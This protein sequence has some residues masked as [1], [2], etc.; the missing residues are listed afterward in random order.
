MPKMKIDSPKPS[1][2]TQGP[3]LL[4]PLTKK[5]LEA[6]GVGEN[7]AVDFLDPEYKTGDPFLLKGMDQAVARIFEAL[8]KKEKIVVFADYDADGIPGAVVLSDFFTAIGYS[9]FDVYIPH[10]YEEGF[11]LNLPAI[12]SFAANGVSLIITIDCGSADREP[13]AKA[14][15]LNM[16]VIITDH[17]RPSDPEP[18]ALVLV[19]PNK[20]GDTYPF[21]GLSGAG[22]VFKLVEALLVR[23]QDSGFMNQATSP[24]PPGWEK[25]L[26]DMVG[27]STLSDMVPLLGENRMFAK[28]G[29]KVFRKSRRPGLRALLKE[30]RIDQANISEEDITFMITPRL[31]AA[32]R[33]GDPSEAFRLLSTKDPKEAVVLAKNLNH[34]NDMRKG[35]VASMIKEAHKKIEARGSLKEV[36][37]VGDPH[38][39]PGLVGLAAQKLSEAY[40]KPVFVWGREGSSI[41]R[42]SCRSGGE[43]DVVTLMEKSS[44][45]F[46]EYGGHSFAGGFSLLEDSVHTLEEELSNSFILVGKT[47]EVKESCVADAELLLSDVNEITWREIERL[48]PFGEGN[49]KPVFLFKEVEISAIKHFGKEKNHLEVLFSGSGKKVK[50]I[51]F[52]TKAEVFGEGVREGGQVDLVATMEKSFFGRPEIRLR[53]EDIMF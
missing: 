46:I 34:L 3:S 8:E 12:E 1:A 36:I 38:W 27:L 50:A 31:N 2:V 39:R 24:I 4:L 10:R 14:N 6:R 9:D 41:I 42:G 44:E 45:Q 7:E 16:D 25:W 17:H 30:L 33:M 29:L 19:N 32:S 23:I 11:G 5:L 22:V 51:K 40:S 15:E 26:L 21:K 43:C 13:I 53:I 37:V 20:T 48:S 18:E 49:A 28:Y 47:A 35:A 52:F